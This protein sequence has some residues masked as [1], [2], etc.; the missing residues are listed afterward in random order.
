MGLEAA[1]KIVR[2]R[3]KLLLSLGSRVR[4]SQRSSLWKDDWMNDGAPNNV[5][6]VKWKCREI[7]S[8]GKAK[9]ALMRFLAGCCLRAEAGALICDYLSCGGARFRRW[10]WNPDYKE[11][12]EWWSRWQQQA[13]GG[14]VSYNHVTC[15]QWRGIQGVGHLA[16]CRVSTSSAS[17]TPGWWGSFG[18]SCRSSSPGHLGLSYR[19]IITLPVWPACASYQSD[20]RHLGSPAKGHLEFSTSNYGG[21]HTTVHSVC[22]EF[23][24]GSSKA[25]WGLEEAASQPKCFEFKFTLQLEVVCVSLELFWAIWDLKTHTHTYTY[26][27]KATD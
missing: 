3:V 13:S 11:F 27:G 8:G 21:L 26:L 7:N 1:S 19:C 23:R 14:G 4:I 6:K 20:H 5:A 22:S 9:A 18:S 15:K 12:G 17:C 25:T 10:R 16:G 2:V 24:A